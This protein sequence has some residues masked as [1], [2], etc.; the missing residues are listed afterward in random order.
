MKDKQETTTGRETMT[1]KPIIVLF[2]IVA[3]LLAE[4][5]I[6]NAQSPYSY[7]WCAIYPGDGNGPGGAMSCYYTSWEQCRTTMFGIGGNCVASPYYHAQS[8]QLPH[9][10]SVKPR[11]HRHT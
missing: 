5:Q 7:P 3:A 4:T 1:R 2:V 10:S 11:H 8:T 6:S 9:R